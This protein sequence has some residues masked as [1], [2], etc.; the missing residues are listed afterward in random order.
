MDPGMS[1]ASRIRTGTG[2]CDLIGSELSRSPTTTLRTWHADHG[3]R[4]R[5]RSPDSHG[6]HGKQYCRRAYSRLSP[7]N[8]E[9]RR[10]TCS[11]QKAG[12]S[13]GDRK[14]GYFESRWGVPQSWDD[15]ILQGPHL[16][17]A[18]PMYKS[19]K[20]HDETSSRIGRR[21]ISKRCLMMQFLSL[22]T[23]R[24]ADRNR[25][26]AD[27]THWESGPARDL[28][29]DRMA[30][31]G[32]K[33]RRTNADSRHYSSRGCSC[34]G[35]FSAGLPDR[36]IESLCVLCGFLSSLIADFS[37]RVSSEER[38][39]SC[40]PSTGLPIKLGHPLQTALVMRTLRLNC[41]TDA[42]ADLWRDVYREAF[43]ADRWASGRPR[44]NRSDLG[45]VTAGSGPPALRCGS[46]RTGGRHSSR[47]MPS[48][49]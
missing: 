31:H 30:E 45:A 19:A 5:S 12:T 7:A 38:Y 18:T 35:V 28:L 23:S 21:Q 9:Q 14:K 36:D 27:Y 37:V 15:V 16:Y 41:V 40:Q 48:S 11:F 17:V 44:E 49:L 32:S 10:W 42:Y 3:G 29:S 33:H 8:H 34:H 24:L 20:S 6:L 46:R 47:S 4:L 39:P 26:D 2:I 1:L 25:Y 43:T 13:P 22:H